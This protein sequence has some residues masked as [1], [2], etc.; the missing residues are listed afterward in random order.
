M[1]E[2]IEKLK[3]PN[4]QSMRR[5]S[6][7]MG[8]LLFSYAVSGISLEPDPVFN[9]L[10]IPFRLDRPQYLPYILLAAAIY[11]SSRYYYFCILLTKTPYSARRDLLNKLVHHIQ[12]KEGGLK[13]TQLQSF[14][15][16]LGPVEF[17]LGPKH[18]WMY[19]RD[20]KKGEGEPGKEQPGAW[21]VTPDASGIVAMPEEGINF[22]NDL[23]ALFP[24]V[25]K[26]RV[27]TRWNYESAEPPMRVRL[28]VAIPN[29]CRL[30]AAFEDI[31]YMAPI[32]LNAVA[33]SVFIWSR[34]GG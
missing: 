31:D 20:R 25:G 12:I 22:Q 19:K 21:S 17:E 30:A 2:F 8:L 33:V 24:S 26:E 4:H 11:G 29:R 32:W 10:G 6:L 28:Y 27:W 15:V 5:F 18:P 13:V 1:S 3:R 34:F 9:L 16:Y 7:A 23:Q 14:G